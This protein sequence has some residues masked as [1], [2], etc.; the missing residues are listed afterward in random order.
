M[1]SRTSRKGRWTIL[2]APLIAIGCS[3]GADE[4]AGGP[5]HQVLDVDY[6]PLRSAFEAD[7]GKVR[8][9]LLG[10]PT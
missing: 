5:P 2:L 10:S 8:A 7:S 4:E 9:I 6:E 3:A 1:G